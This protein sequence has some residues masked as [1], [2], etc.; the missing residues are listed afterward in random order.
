MRA[1]GAGEV[2]KGIEPTPVERE[3]ERWIDEGPIRDAAVAATERAK[4]A[5]PRRNENMSLDPEVKEKVEA[6]LE[7]RRAAKLSDRLLQAQIALEA[8]RF[9]DARRMANSLLK[10]MS[11]V[12]AVHEV[13]GLSN[14]RLG[15]WREAAAALEIARSQRGRVEDLPVLADCYR[16]LKRWTAVDEIWEEI[17]GVSPSHEVM[18]EGRIVVAGALADRGELKEAI[19]LM[20]RSA[21]IPKKVRDHHLRQWYVLGDL[22][23]RAGNLHKA[24]EMFR[25]VALHDADFADVEDRIAS[26]R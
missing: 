17:K 19:D 26:L 25:R 24:R 6:S 12:S 16:A 13:I 10:E 21:A 9:T 5:R 8:E 3:P 7:P 1:R 18:A 15:R 14:Y 20:V 11:H 4:P 22:Y 2:R 23:D